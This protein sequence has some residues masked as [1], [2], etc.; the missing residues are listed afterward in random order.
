MIEEAIAEGKMTL[1]QVRAL[2][3]ST[4]H[5]PMIRPDQI[6]KIARYGI[7]PAFNGYQVQGN[8]KGG[9]FL[10]AFGEQY[11][12]WMAHVL[13]VDRSTRSY[14]SFSSAEASHRRHAVAYPARPRSG[15]K[16]ACRCGAQRRLSRS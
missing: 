2:R 5:T 1:E 13:A 7:M 8:I 12:S 11:M 6:E 4:E 10:K 3:I 16:T 14:G 15:S 9:A